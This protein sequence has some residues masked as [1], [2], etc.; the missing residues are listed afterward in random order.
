MVTE[1]A[2]SLAEKPVPVA[3]TME[4]GELLSRSKINRGVIVKVVCIAPRP[5]SETPTD[6]GPLGASGTWNEVD[7]APSLSV[8]TER[9]VLPSKVKLMVA[10]APKP[11]PER[12]TVVPG[13]PLEVPIERDDV[14]VKFT[15]GALPIVTEYEPAGRAG[16]LYLVMTEPRESTEP[17]ITCWAPN[18]T[19][20][21]PCPVANP[22]PVRVTRVPTGPRLGEMENL[23]STVKLA[24][25]VPTVTV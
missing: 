22:S 13:G 4:P 24:V 9:I 18:R 7:S 17:V 3:V 19:G 15:G 1:I 6:R 21:S 10:L 14:I 23:A 5:A 20:N 8:E 25:T 11:E 16:T 2:L 12:L